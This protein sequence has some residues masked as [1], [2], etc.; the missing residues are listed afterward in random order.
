MR[1]DP[2][3]RDKQNHKIHKDIKKYQK[4]LTQ[5]DLQLLNEKS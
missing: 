3:F 4:Q 1:S 2:D 5:S